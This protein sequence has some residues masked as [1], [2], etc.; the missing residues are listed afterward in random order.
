MPEP[1]LNPDVMSEFQDRLRPAVR[2][3]L[4]RVSRIHQKELAFTVCPH[5][6]TE[7]TYRV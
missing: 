4:R 6:G 1:D 5:L 2:A 7:E 3:P